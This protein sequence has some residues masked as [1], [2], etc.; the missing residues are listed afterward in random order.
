MKKLY[1]LAKKG[2]IN[3]K[4][5]VIDKQEIIIHAPIE[6]VWET[7]ADIG[8]WPEWYTGVSIKKQPEKY[9][10][11]RYFVW[12][13]NGARIKSRLAKIDKPHHLAWIG[14]V[15]WIKAVHVWKL[16]EIE[17]R[18]TRVMVEESMQGF[19]VSLF[20]NRET[21]HKAL[22]LWL[23]LLKIRAERNNPQRRRTLKDKKPAS[24]HSD[25]LRGIHVL[26]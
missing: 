7:L 25:M 18:K 11:G 23:N 21:L 20:M 9:E 16:L 13:Q 3:Q 1:L 4:A 14:S 6:L 2:E 8:G 26:S 5:P 24:H 15:K 19:L 10:V 17:K 12:K 22:H